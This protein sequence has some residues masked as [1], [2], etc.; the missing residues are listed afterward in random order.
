MSVPRVT[1]ADLKAWRKAYGLRQGPA[2]ALLGWSRWQV[3]R[4]EQAV[5]TPLP[6]AQALLCLLLRYPAVQKVACEYVECAPLLK[7]DDCS[8][9]GDT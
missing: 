4:A 2:G 8:P 3:C 1:G 7:N 5:T 9:H 6:T